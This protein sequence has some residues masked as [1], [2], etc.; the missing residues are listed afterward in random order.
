MVEGKKHKRHE[1]NNYNKILPSNIYDTKYQGY[2]T[3]RTSDCWKTPDTSPV[4]LP[5]FQ[6]HNYTA[7]SPQMTRKSEDQKEAW[8]FSSQKHNALNV[9]LRLRKQL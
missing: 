9:Y 4:T 6:D 5:F 1:Q 7:A 3:G 2:L 8:L